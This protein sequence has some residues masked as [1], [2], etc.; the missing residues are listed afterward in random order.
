M[1]N[2]VSRLYLPKRTLE[3]CYQ[4]QMDRAHIEGVQRR[5]LV[6]IDEEL[7]KWQP[8]VNSWN[9]IKSF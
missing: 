6:R 5:V 9:L 4:S 2:L 7:Q 8:F 1:F 3:R